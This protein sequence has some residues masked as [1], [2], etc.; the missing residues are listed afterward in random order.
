VF[1]SWAR[2]F[3]S[4]AANGY[5]R[6]V[7]LPELFG[8]ALRD[9]A[10]AHG[11]EWEDR[12][13]TFGEIDAWST[14]FAHALLARGV[15]AGDRLAV[16]LPNR[17]EYI[18]LALAC[19]K[20]GIIIVPI[21]ILYKEREAG[22]ILRDSAPRAAV[23]HDAAPAPG[24]DAWPLDALL[25]DAA[26]HG[27]T[28]V[29]SRVTA[30]SPAALVYTS[31]TTGAAKGAI[32]TH[33]NFAANASTLVRAWRFTADDHLLLAL[34]L[35][36]VHGLGNGV[37]CWLASGCVVRLLPRFEQR[38]AADD[39]ATF[40]PTVFFGVP[41]MYVR[42]LELDL[43]AA[44]RIG[45]DAR[46]F[47]SGSAPL[48]A[49]V[50]ESFQARF[51]HRILERYGMTETLM[52]LGNP[53]DGERRAGTVGLPL[54]GVHTRIVDGGA[55]VAD[56]ARGELW[57]RSPTVCAGYWNR[58]DATA[59][60]FADGWFR[61]GD[62]ASR[63]TDG[64]ITLHGRQSD[65]IISGGFNIYPRE[66]EEVLAEH[67]IVAEAAVAGLQVAAR[68]EIPIAFVVVRDDAALDSAALE[69]HC[70]AQLASFKV[71]RAFV[72]VASLPRTALGKV[73]KRAL[74]ESY[75]RGR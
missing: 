26:V 40:R 9:R 22:H 68:G 16:Y 25:R 39:F 6:P 62:I 24:V 72:A 30:A 63:A 71:P 57:I 45:H 2:R 61:T 20:A 51:G 8:P 60:A 48:A 15:R 31:G 69:A 59:A 35:F 64:Y 13:Y 44:Q 56:G 52:T 38:T 58:P 33:G 55:D 50:L 47:V 49:N 12:S 46:L 65:L 70:R 66:I 17:P 7:T 4:A 75:V 43:D 41:T 73:Q 19:F 53:Y 10:A 37:M 42:L 23:I 11:L 32:V 21:N 29:V 34:P 74:V 27:I 18:V 54:P 67:P 36:H 14:Q 28:P 1:A 3:Y 5:T